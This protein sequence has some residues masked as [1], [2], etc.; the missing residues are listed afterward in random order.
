MNNI[1]IITQTVWLEMLRRKDVYIILALQAFCTLMLTSI[2][3]FGS[4]VPS[5]YIMDIGLM[6]A[7]LLSIGLSIILGSRQFPAEIR[8]GTI[9]SMLT[10]PISRLEFLIGKWLGLWCGMLATNLLFY[11]IIS[12]VTLS[13][14]FI[15][16]PTVLLQV[17]CLHA[18]L[19]GTIIAISLFF[20]MFFSQ[21]AA[22]AATAV[23]VILCYLFLP[24]IPNLLAFEHG[25]RAGALWSIY[26]IAPHMELFDMRARVLHNRGIL[27]IGTFLTTLVYGLLI[28]ATFIALAW[29]LFR[30]KHFKRGEQL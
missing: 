8:S 30:R 12:G 14:N 20:T 17:F 21:G 18:V 5:S 19:L 15:F 11:L 27:D 25:W 16:E 13:R 4:D 24:R 10:K 29:G 28:T 23:F 7:F 9:F 26:H 1:L 22:G 2:N 6:L 3:A